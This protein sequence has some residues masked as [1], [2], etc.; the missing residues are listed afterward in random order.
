VLK[1]KNIIMTGVI[2]WL[3]ANIGTALVSFTQDQTRE[4]IIENERTALLR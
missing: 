3:F 2:I 1:N 4:Q